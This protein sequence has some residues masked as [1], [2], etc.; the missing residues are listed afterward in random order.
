MRSEKPVPQR[1]T[2]PSRV[3]LLSDSLVD[4][5]AAGEVVERPASVVKELVE[6]ALDAAASRIEVQIRGGGAALVAVTD[7]GFGMSPDEMGLALRRHATSK[8]STQADLD[9]IMSFG[10]R[11]EAL[12]AIAAVSR[13]RIRSRPRKADI[14][15]E[16]QIE[17]SKLRSEREFGCPAGTRIEVADLFA[18]VPARRKFLKAPTTEWGHAIDWLGRLALALP[19]IHFEVR[20]DDQDPLVWP[21]TEEPMERIAAVLGESQARGLI[22]VEREDEV[23]H[24]D[25]YV[26]GPQ[27]SRANGNAIHLYVNGRPVRDKVLRHA[28]THAYRDVL[29]RGRFPVAVLFLSVLPDRVDVNVHPAKWEVRF[30][31]PQAIHGLV[32]GAV[33]D[34][35]ESREYW[36]KEPSQ[37]RPAPVHAPSLKGTSGDRNRE[38]TRG[39]GD[40]LLARGKALEDIDRLRELPSDPGYAAAEQGR[41]EFSRL[42]LVGQ[43]LARYLVLEGEK[44]MLLVDQHAAH[45]R[46]LYERLRASWLAGGVEMQGLLAPES[47]EIGAR[48]ATL[49][50]EAAASI[51][52]LGFDVED[53]GEGSVLIRAIPALLSGANPGSLL[54]DLS[55]EVEQGESLPS[56]D[57]V[58]VRLLAAADRILAG[59]ACHGAR[60]FGERLPE[61]EQRAILAG[62]DEIPWAPTCPHGRP[63]VVLME[64]SEIDARFGRHGPRSSS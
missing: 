23:G 24:L 46:V 8:I 18:A 47:V 52:K 54:G 31:N 62:L 44:G 28:V 64:L 20:R 34:A 59:L 42:H 29:P 9:G 6:N 43:M 35:M 10:F 36:R 49:L 60:R 32:R 45:E 33:R 37:E 55:D 56:A 48:A 27:Q 15:F 53:F 1:D 19:E 16:I 2:G 63:V 11:G 39:Q 17:A 13:M 14:G 38:Q 41:V 21:G 26:S 50:G 5:I 4:Q 7:D 51:R 30:E 40:W 25:A 12:P 3:R 22:H 57:P 58:D 61:A